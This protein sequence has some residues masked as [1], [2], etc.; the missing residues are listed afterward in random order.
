MGCLTWCLA[1][2]VNILKSYVRDI[3]ARWLLP[4]V[5]HLVFFKIITFTKFFVGSYGWSIS[6]SFHS[7]SS[8]SICQ[9]HEELGNW[10]GRNSFCPENVWHTGTFWTLRLELQALDFRGREISFMLKVIF[11]VNLFEIS[12]FPLL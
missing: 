9:I 6:F 5:E 4:E 8:C 1:A 11:K 7:D 10:D 2:N 12:F 3:I